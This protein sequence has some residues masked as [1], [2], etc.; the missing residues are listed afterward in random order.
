MK[1]FEK[2]ALGVMVLFALN[3]GFWGWYQF[4][5]VAWIFHSNTSWISRFV[6]SLAGFSAL[7]FMVGLSR[8]FKILQRKNKDIFN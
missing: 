8:N 6:Y 3:T 7:Y 1:K 2:V 5:F 4:D